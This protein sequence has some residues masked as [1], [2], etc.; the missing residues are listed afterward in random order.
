MKVLSIYH[1][2]A[3]ASRRSTA[4]YSSL[5]TRR[6]TVKQFFLVRYSQRAQYSQGPSGSAKGLN[7]GCALQIAPEIE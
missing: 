5:K 2:V 6:P 4:R 1:T 3:A 7:L